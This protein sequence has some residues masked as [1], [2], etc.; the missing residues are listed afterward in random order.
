MKVDTAAILAGGKGTRLTAV[1]GDIPKALVSIGGKPVLE[2]QLDLLAAYGINDVRIFAGHLANQIRKFTGDG[3]RFNLRVTVDVEEQP[4]GSAGAVLQRLNS[5]PEHFLVLYGDTMLAVD[6]GRFVRRHLAQGADLTTFVHP[7][8]HPQDS[9]LVEADTDGRITALHP[10]PHPKGLYF[11]NLVNAALYVIR[12]DVL[13][14]W[15]REVVKRDFAKDV[16][17]ALLAAGGHIEAYNSTEYIKDMGTPERLEK[18]HRDWQEGRI[19]LRDDAYRESAVFLDRDGTLNAE[20][21]FISTPAQ[22]DLLPGVAAAL[23][24]LRGAGYR[25]V[26]LTNQPVIARGEA[27]EQD[28]AA[29]HR[30]ME[31]EM[32]LQGAFLD[33]IYYC[34]HHPDNGFPGERPELKGPCQCRKPATG[35]LQQACRDLALDPTRSWMV[36]DTTVDMEM[37]R[38]GGLRSI[39]VRT[40]AG[41]R[42]GKFPEAKPDYVVADIGAAVDL[43]LGS[44][45]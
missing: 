4:L 8:D 17:P 28:V 25:L 11:A 7:N 38:R 12:R 41:G 3:S 21:G 44:G 20:N 6:L 30:K 14:P 22:F 29:I 23:K 35:M 24:K 40:G 45:S 9:D 32:G 1:V 31:W 15:S 13:L 10:Y 27:S 2:H 37:A 43:V 19:H 42:D 16:L 26:V 39:L 36:G 5:L 34:P 33:A 18:V